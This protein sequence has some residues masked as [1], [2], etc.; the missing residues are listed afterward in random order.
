MQTP[1][2]SFKTIRSWDGSQNRAFEELCYQLRDPTPDGWKLWKP[3][4]PD[5]GYEWY[6]RHRNGTERGWQVKYAFTIEELLPLMKESVVSVT[7]RRPRCRR[8]TFCIPIDL[9]DSFDPPKRKSALQ[10]YKDATKT[11]AKTIPGAAGIKFE[12]ESGGDILQR[13]TKPEHIGTARF[14]W[15]QEL[16]GPGWMQERLESAVDAAGDR[17][18]PELNVDLPVAAAIEGLGLSDTFVRQYRAR[19]GEFIKAANR[20]TLG[21][22]TGVGV[23][24]EVRALSCALRGIDQSIPET[25][26]VDGRFDREHMLTLLEPLWPLIDAAHPVIDRERVET[27][28]R[29]AHALRELSRHL[30]RLVS[31]LGA[32]AS[33]TASSGLLLLTGEAGQGKTHLFCDAIG[34]VVSDGRPGVVVFGGTFR[35]AQLFPDLAASLGI[36]NIGAAELFGAMRAAAE[37]TGKP[38]VLLIDALNDTQDP[39]RWEFDLPALYAEVQRHAPWI[40]LGVS[41]RT[42]YVDVIQ[43]DTSERMTR[44]RHPGLAGREIEAIGKYFQAAGLDVPRS[45]M[46]LPEFSSPLFLKLYCEGFAEQQ[47]SDASDGH[48][49]IT[50]VFARFL[51]AKT[52][53][54][55]RKLRLSPGGDAVGQAVRAF[56]NAIPTDDREMLRRSDARSLVDAFA[57]NRTEWPNTLYGALL[58]EG[59]L[60]EDA[61]HFSDSKGPRR[62]I[63]TYI[64]FQRLSDYLSAEALIREV[65]DADELQ[66]LSQPGGRLH[67]PLSEARAGVTR[68][69]CVLLPERFGLEF[70]DLAL[71]DRTPHEAHRLEEAFLESVVARRDDAVSERAVEL[72]DE[73][74]GQSLELYTSALR[75]MVS[76]A[77][78]PGH[79]L[80][81]EYLHQYLFAKSLPDRDTTWGFATYYWLDDEEPIDRLIRWLRLGPSSTSSDTD[82][83]LAAIPLVWAL[84]SPNRFL[85][86]YVTKTLATGLSGRLRVL[87]SLLER[88]AAVNDPYVIQRL[89]VVIHGAVLIGGRTDAQAAVQCSRRL[90]QLVRD[91]EVQPDV[92]L[93]D[94]ARGA[95]EWCHRSGHVGEAEYLRTCPPYGASPPESVRD[96]AELEEAFERR[97][98]DDSPGYSSLLGSIFGLGDFGRYEIDSA[99]HH[100]SR[101]PLEQAPPDPDYI[102]H[103]RSKDSLRALLGEPLDDEDVD[104]EPVLIR[105]YDPGRFY[106]T[107]EARAWVFERVISLGW[108]PDRFGAFDLEVSRRRSGRESHKPERFGKKYQWIA[109]HEFLARIADNFHMADEVDDEPRVY[110]GPWHFLERDIDP[111]LP[112]PKRARDDDG[113]TGSA[114]TFAADRPGTWWEPEGP[115][116]AASDWPVSR[117]WAEHSDG[118][119]ELGSL[120]HSTDP[121]GTSWVTLHA[122][123]SWDEEKLDDADHYERERRDMWGYLYTWLVKPAD[124]DAAI[125]YLSTHTLMGKWMPE[126]RDIIDVA[127]LAEMPLATAAT[128][129]E[130]EWQPMGR[131]DDAPDLAVF[132]AWEGYCWEGHILDC[133]IEE[134]VRARMPAPPLYSAGKLHWIPGSR[135]WSDGDGTV[136]VRHADTSDESHSALLVRADWLTNTL[137]SLNLCLIA[138][139]YGDKR[140]VSGGMSSR[141]VGGWTE[142]N[143]VGLL[144]DGT[145]SIGTRR[146]AILHA[147]SYDPGNA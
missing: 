38:F 81:G 101:Y 95:M 19:R 56:A 146:D 47:G 116:Y 143:A 85:R 10:K 76:V 6:I 96:Q 86:D 62:E 39:Y 61:V 23:T 34:R 136:V 103:D 109:F 57:P 22:Y 112:P 78:R 107:A 16:F 66:R 67:F 37:A 79:P 28:S 80:N 54:I 99:M 118:I 27:A 113:V 142:Y 128:D 53:R 65:G 52:S 108:T 75:A 93:R 32:P 90:A 105:R 63:V 43:S 100:F 55:D 45:P 129:Y 5:G 72:F 117:D 123:L 2:T 83:E 77:V 120:L 15:D 91:P 139:L 58:S 138:G 115:T 147:H 11:W 64:T 104:I 20:V 17:Y 21:R 33:R 106:P 141:F 9:P 119:P 35:G 49:H 110:G 18:Q 82:V 7:K 135:C 84:S 144:R 127:Y 60:S 40:S 137:D 111:T 125:E 94:A 8:L 133:S 131:H 12:L 102:E 74:S 4:N 126:G 134:T 48:A 92:Q 36:G 30:G 124:A 31:F 114:P 68:A 41:V 98:P 14:F 73:I 1:P 24:T 46:M 29:L 25:G 70:T 88:F 13:L 42:A 122:H 51:S 59:V 97:R 50:K 26:I 89:A 87:T 3:G 145:W 130:A 71:R 69:L 121:D 132:P 44:V 140:L